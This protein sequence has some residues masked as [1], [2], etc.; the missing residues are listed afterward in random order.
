MKYDLIIRPE[1]QSDIQGAFGWY[2]DRV[3]GLGKEYLRCIDAAIAQII[4]RLQHI[5]LFIIISAEFYHVVFLS[6]SFI[7]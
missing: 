7:S 3:S 6:E 1:A 4:V 5:Q 2:E